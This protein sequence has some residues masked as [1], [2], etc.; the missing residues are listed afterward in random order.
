[1]IQN[2]YTMH[3][4]ASYRANIIKMVYGTPGQLI[5]YV[6]GGDEAPYTHEVWGPEQLDVSWTVARDPST[7]IVELVFYSNSE[8]G[9]VAAGVT[10]NVEN[11]V[12]TIEYLQHTPEL[13]PGKDAT[14]T[15][16]GLT[17][18]LKCS[19]C[20]KWITPQQVI[21]IKMSTVLF[22]GNGGS[23][24]IDK[25]EYR[26]NTSM[27]LPGSGFTRLG[28]KLIGWSTKANATS[29][30]YSLG[31]TV[32]GLQPDAAGNI[33][34]YAVWEVLT[35]GEADYSASTTGSNY[36]DKD[37]DDSDKVYDY[38]KLNLDRDAL[39]AKGYKTVTVTL[40]FDVYE[41]NDGY[42]NF[43]IYSPT[44]KNLYSKADKNGLESPKK[45][46]KRHTVVFTLNLSDLDTDCGFII[47]WGA[48]GDWGSDEWTLG[49]T[50]ITVEAK[51]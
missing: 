28:H 19:V 20:G 30:M 18:G 47:E 16:T 38:V 13:V 21:D 23:G 36:R 39:I 10:Y 9:L 37:I 32:S 15:Q 31:Q 34:L 8:G 27:I 45:E 40:T 24:T 14:Y 42:Q 29:A 41:I 22:N 2:G 44:W 51:K 5:H 26:Y 4:T 1:M 7:D 49:W 50:H 46:W 33:H 6:E 25:E 11:L 43:W 3:I 35:V 48:Y 12:I 17:D